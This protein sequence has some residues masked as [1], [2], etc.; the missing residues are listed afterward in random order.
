MDLYY[1]YNPHN[2]F[3][4]E[5]DIHAILRKYGLPHYRV[6]NRR[7][8]QTA[9]VH[10]TYV[11]RVEYTTPDGQPAQLAPCPQGCM[12]LQD[13]SYECL[14]FEGD[15]VLG[16]CVATYLRHKYPEK[17]QGFLTDARK[18]LVNNERIG[19]LSKQIGLNRFYVI[20]RHN[21][22]SAAIS[23]RNNLKKLGDIFEA[24][25]G[26]LWTDCGN[27]FDIVYSFVVSVME[28]H[29]DIEDV[30]TSITN[31]KDIF[32]KYCQKEFRY[33]PMY[34]MLSNDPKKNEIRVAVCDETGKALGF[35]VG[36]TRKKAEQLAAKEALSG[37]SVEVSFHNET[38]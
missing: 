11:R 1:P 8:F 21:E 29:L 28:A 32:Q 22:E 13:E 36:T 10:T 14:E 25:L 4:T 12:P 34:T 18:E 3:F 20:S 35:G 15:S 27:R 16:V 37:L 24:F 9:M 19:Y 31:Y 30:V 7:I 23:G 2:R 26:A 6:S 17:K 33:T 5:K 38:S